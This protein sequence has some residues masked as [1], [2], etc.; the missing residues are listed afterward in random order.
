MCV[1]T[2]RHRHA[3]I[4]IARD[5]IGELLDASVPVGEGLLG[6]PVDRSISGWE[7]HLLMLDHLEQ[8][9]VQL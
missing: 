3:C 6:D 4:V 7:A 1:L 5:G 8:A 2:T 9:R